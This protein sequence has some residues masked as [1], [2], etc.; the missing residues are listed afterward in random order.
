M[1]A[2]ASLVRATL[3]VV[4]VL[5][6]LPG[7]A[8]ESLAAPDA[9]A[10]IAD[11]AA[12]SAALFAEAYKVFSHPRCTNCHP[13]GERPFQGERDT[14]RPH[15]PPV[16]RGADGFGTPAMRCYQCHQSANF[17]PGRV[18]GHAHWHLAPAAMAWQGKSA[19]AICAQIKDAARN[20]GRSLAQVAEH[21]G[22]DSLVGWAW[23]PGGGREP[24]PGTQQAVGALVDA[25]I[26]AGAACPT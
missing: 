4:L 24:A 20:G 8:A 22:H 15:Q 23:A 1:S 18:P 14:S 17:E 25:W 9:F 21:I 11:P 26:A 6:P 7:A 2:P 10:G 13:A 5:L 16:V 19:G 12:R 3:V